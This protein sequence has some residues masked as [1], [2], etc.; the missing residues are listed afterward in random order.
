MGLEAQLKTINAGI[1]GVSIQQRKDSLVLVATLPAKVGGRKPHQQRIPTGHK[2]D[3][4]GLK[5][6]HKQALTL[7]AAKASGTFSW[8][9]WSY[10]PADTSGQQE[11]VL[12]VGEAVTQLEQDFWKGK[13]RTS[14]AERTWSRVKAETDRLPQAATLT[15][16]LLVAVG[17]QQE[18]GSRTRQESL[19][20]FKRLAVLVGMEGTDR[21]DAIKT[22]YE[23]AVRDIP[24]VEEVLALMQAMPTDHK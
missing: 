2:A 9:D 16:D 13:I 19:K 21:L 17:D 6:A 24:S 18:P 22:P 5:L 8:G 10:Q 4:H 15:M 1:K 23:P 7:A 20:V 12:T 11:R 3:A 14:A